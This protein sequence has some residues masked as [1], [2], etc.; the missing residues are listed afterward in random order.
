MI[1][2]KEK[3]LSTKYQVP[4]CGRQAKYE[5]AKHLKLF[6]PAEQLKIIAEVQNSVENLNSKKKGR[7]KLSQP[8]FN[9]T[10]SQLF[11][12]QAHPRRKA[13][14]K[15]LLTSLLSGRLLPTAPDRCHTWFRRSKTSPIQ[16]GNGS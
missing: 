9:L 8:F 2:L 16:D 4:A 10:T 7:D 15:L 14:A 3:V 5:I 13:S 11:L 6:S 1:R 12:E